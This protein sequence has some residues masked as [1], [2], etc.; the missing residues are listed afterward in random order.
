MRARI[1]FNFLVRMLFPNFEYVSWFSF[2]IPDV[3]V[4]F[5]ELIKLKSSRL[6][7]SR[8]LRINVLRSLEKLLCVTIFTL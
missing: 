5:I 6:P 1:R 3:R 4:V 2:F 7:E 8:C